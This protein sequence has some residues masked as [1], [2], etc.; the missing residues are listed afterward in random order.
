MPCL[1]I[2]VSIKTQAVTMRSDDGR[3][4]ALPARAGAVRRTAG[5][6][7]AAPR[8][9]RRAAT[10]GAAGVRVRP[11]SRQRTLPRCPGFASACR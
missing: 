6:P 11:A 9:A 8:G 3:N 5:G 1:E 2:L 7:P 4:A 10:E